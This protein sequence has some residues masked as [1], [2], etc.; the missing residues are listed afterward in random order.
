MSTSKSSSLR[1][2]AGGVGLA[3][4]CVVG[5][6]QA[7]TGSLAEM[8][9]AVEQN[10]ELAVQRARTDAARSSLDVLESFKSPKLSVTADG[11]LISSDNEEQTVEASIEQTIHDWG[12]LDADLLAADLEIEVNDA[13]LSA[14][15]QRV[16]ERVAGAYV[17]AMRAAGLVSALELAIKDITEIEAV[18]A[19]R[20]EQNVS[21][22]T[23]LL[24]V[25]ARSSQYRS[26]RIQA[27]GDLRDAELQLIQL[28]G[29]TPPE[30]IALDC[31]AEFDERSLVQVAID[32]SHE[33][34]V[35]RLR[36][37][38]VRAQEQ[39]LASRQLPTIVGGV[40]FTENLDT[41]AGG[42]RAFIALR[43]DYDLGNRYDAELATLRAE[44]AEATF[45]E[46]RLIQSIVRVSAGLMNTH[47]VEQSRL[48][49][50]RDMISLREEQ[51]A[52]TSR[53][54]KGGQATI[55]E[56]MNVQ[57]DLSDARAALVEAN[58]A[59]CGAVLTLEQ[60]T[61]RD[62]RAGE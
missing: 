1:K 33:V 18:M 55:I 44:A 56:L 8:L 13:E 42:S 52:S 27:V 31:R 7:P 9:A 54:F 41:S 40:G 38:G 58:A 23:D 20:V 16:R 35:E 32:N 26:S 4:S 43:Y 11:D 49:I 45:E 59:A 30:D 10:P 51:L 36:V 21:P 12:A 6:S 3:L 62:L 28:T 46:Q 2:I 39:G 19:R 61:G 34:R 14:V 60:I 17:D 24:L 57:Q 22:A 37:D 5:A 48:I 50:L 29:F 47:A 15:R 25:R 53:K